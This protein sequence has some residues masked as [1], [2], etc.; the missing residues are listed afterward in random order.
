MN[1]EFGALCDPLTKQLPQ[2][3]RLRRT[4]LNCCKTWQ[5]DADAITRLS[6][7]QH[8]SESERDKARKRL[9]ATIAYFYKKYGF[10]AAE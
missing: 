7:H 1:I 5:Q 2:P 4:W 10:G 6:I 3:K 8:L 9:L